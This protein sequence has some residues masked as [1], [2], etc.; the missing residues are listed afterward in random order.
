VPLAAAEDP[1][2]R[3]RQGSEHA[4]DEHVH[5]IVQKT[6][7]IT[8]PS[9]RL[10]FARPA[11]PGIGEKPQTW[12]GGS[13]IPSPTAISTRQK[14]VIAPMAA[15]R[16]RGKLGST[17]EKEVEMS[18]AMKTPAR[19]AVGD[20]L[21]VAGHRVGE[22]ERLAEI[23]EVLGEAGHERFRVRWEDGHET[24]IYPGSDA[25]VRKGRGRKERS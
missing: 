19:A 24:I 11:R 13:P 3:V 16:S 22:A 18:K 20:L 2:R 7:F 12:C 21:A 9:V 6:S 15:A 5:P 17:L 14:S 23:L 25:I 4:D 8:V 10:R 1:E